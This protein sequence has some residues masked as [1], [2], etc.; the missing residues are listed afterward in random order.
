MVERADQI[1]AGGQVS[2][3]LAAQRAV[4]LREQ[5]GG[6]ADV[7]D[8][9]HVDR[10]EEAGKVADH[11]AAERNQNGVAV[12]TVLGEF[13]S[14]ALDRVKPLVLLASGQDQPRGRRCEACIDE[15]ALSAGTQSAV[16]QLVEAAAHQRKQTGADLDGVSDGGCLDGDNG[17]AAHDSFKDTAPAC[18]PRGD[19]PAHGQ[20]TSMNGT[21]D[22]SK[23]RSLRG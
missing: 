3:R 20:T 17:G 10:R 22:V 5:R 6:H 8:A 18:S 13:F 19:H 14:K 9:A 11:A 23:R 4:H 12:G 21:T 2:A 7:A 1:L 16:Q 15:G